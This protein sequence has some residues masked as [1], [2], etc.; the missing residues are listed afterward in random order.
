MCLFGVVAGWHPLQKTQ[1]IL[2]E[3]WS[4]DCLINLQQ[5]SKWAFIH[6][7]LHPGTVVRG[8]VQQSPILEQENSSGAGD[9]Y[10]DVVIWCELQLQ[11][12]TDAPFTSY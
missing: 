6:P 10:L 2:W 9:I 7:N 5:T 12:V 1:Q 4:R 8:Q 3:S 11:E